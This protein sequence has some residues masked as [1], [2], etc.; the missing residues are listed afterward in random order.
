MMRSV[1]AKKVT[2]Y[3]LIVSCFWSVFFSLQI[4]TTSAKNVETGYWT[5]MRTNGIHTYRVFNKVKT[6]DEA[7]KYCRSLG[8]HLV[9]ITD[10]T[11]NEFVKGIAT[12]DG[13]KN[14]FWMG[15]YREYIGGSWKWVTG[16]KAEYFNW[17][18]GEPNNY[19]NS[20]EYKTE[21][22]AKYNSGN[23]G[24]VGQW[25]D[26][27]SSAADSDFHDIKNHG[28]I[29]EWEPEQANVIS[30]K[31]AKIKKVRVV[32]NGAN[33]VVKWNKAGSIS[34]YQVQYRYDSGKGKTKQVEAQKTSIV[35]KRLKR[36]SFCFIKVRAYSK[37]NG[38]MYYGKWSK[39]K[40]VYIK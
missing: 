30:A 4:Q 6:W 34:G 10:E 9:T 7:E 27:I 29:C 18:I 38:K 25:N 32:K 12:T 19:V 36:Q 1:I 14:L 26:N 13:N 33:I 2:K 23:G 20:N 11:E 5:T 8:G 39:E 40:K 31:P 22:Y 24:E 28:F 21:F 17:A 15:L 37:I 35:L 3:L 16:E